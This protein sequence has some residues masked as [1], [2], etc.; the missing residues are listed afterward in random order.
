MQQL[1]QL[2]QGQ[3]QHQ[4]RLDNVD[5]RRC[6]ARLCDSGQLFTTLVSVTDVAG[7]GI[8]GLV[9]PNP[10]IV[11]VVGQVSPLFPANMNALRGLTIQN[12]VDL[13]AFYN[14]TFGI[15]VVAG[16]SPFL[17]DVQDAFYRWITR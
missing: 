15:V 4:H 6:N 17:N 9:A 14:D 10:G 5:A 3:V 2:E 1:L 8:P 16:T 7:P 11:P 13:T 12:I